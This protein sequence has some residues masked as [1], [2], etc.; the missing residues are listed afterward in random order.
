MNRKKIATII[1]I[2]AIMAQ[3]LV[4][5]KMIWDKESV[6][7]TGKVFKFKTAPIDPIDPFRGRFIYLN[8]ESDTMKIIDKTEWQINDDVY[9]TLSTDSSGFASVKS[10]SPNV[11]DGTTNYVK[12]KIRYISNDKPKLVTIRYPFEKFYMEESDA[13]KAEKIYRNASIHQ[14]MNGY[15]LVYIKNGDSALKDVIVKGK[16]LTQY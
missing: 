14:R 11:P 10:I 12:A 15:A 5:S 6:I 9:V 3:W 8:F 16:S 2:L 13:P 4:P 1:F 7:E